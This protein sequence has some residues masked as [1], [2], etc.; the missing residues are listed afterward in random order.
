MWSM[1]MIYYDD[2]RRN[3]WINKIMK[4]SDML[5]IKMHR[6]TRDELG[7]LE[8]K[9]LERTFRMVDELWKSQNPTA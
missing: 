4:Y 2:R 9:E 5:F 8:N 7:A 1:S 3:G 6:Y